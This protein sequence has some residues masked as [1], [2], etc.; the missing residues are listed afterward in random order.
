MLQTSNGCDSLV[1]L[2]LTVIPEA[3]SE[4]DFDICEGELFNGIPIENDTVFIQF[5]QN[6]FGCDSTVQ[7]NVN[8]LPQSH[9]E[10]EVSLCEGESYNGTVYTNDTIM[11]DLFTNF[12]GC[13][14]TVQTTVI[15]HPAPETN[16]TIIVDVTDENRIKGDDL[17][18]LDHARLSNDT[19]IISDTL[20]TIE[21][22]DSILNYIYI[23]L[24]PVET[25]LNVSLCEGDAYEGEVYTQSTILTEVYEAA[26]GLDSTVYTTIKVL[27]T[28]V[29]NNYVEICAGSSYE[30]AGEL[31]TTSGLY[32]DSLFTSNGCDSIIITQLEVLPVENTASIIEVCEGESADIHGSKETQ[33][34][35]Y[36]NTFT[37]ANGCD[38]MSTIELIVHPHFEQVLENQICIGETF[39]GI[40]IQNDTTFVENYNTIFGCDSTIITHISVL[41]H[42][43]TTIYVTLPVG[44]IYNEVTYHENSTLNDVIAASNGCDST[45]ITIITV[46][47]AVETF[48]NYEICE[49]ESVDGVSYFQ[50]TIFTQN[51]LTTQGFDSLVT[52]EITVNF[53]QY[54]YLQANSCEYPEGTEQEITYTDQN[55]CDSI[56][57]TTYTHIESDAV[58]LEITLCE[59]EE[60]EGFAYAESTT[61]VQESQ[62]QFGCDSTTTLMITVLPTPQINLE[63]IE[64]FCATESITIDLG[65]LETVIWTEQS[66]TLINNTISAGGYYYVQATNAFGCSTIDTIWVPAPTEIQAEVSYNP[67]PCYEPTSASITIDTVYGGTAPYT[68]SLNGEIQNN[69]HFGNLTNGIFEINIQDANGCEF[70]DVIVIEEEYTPLEVDLGEDLLIEW[71]ESVQLNPV[72]N[73]PS[74]VDQVFWTPSET[75]DCDDCLTP[76]ATPNET[77]VY[78][79][80]VVTHDGCETSDEVL[81]RVEKERNIYIPNAF[82][83]NDDGTNDFF[84]VYPG[85]GV[86]EVQLMRIYDRW[87]NNVFERHNFDPT[88]EQLGWDGNFRGKHMNP[89]VFVY[90]VEVL[91]ED[92]VVKLYKGDVTLL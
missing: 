38:S 71:G 22:C 4:L 66:D 36:E 58:E 34:G 46:I 82:T 16:D 13:D 76:T 55:G 91:F 75:L 62:N 44:G 85:Q 39:E 88:D 57:M 17:P 64:Q 83:P 77:T 68:Y 40:N 86:E 28:F 14:S 84:T 8:L 31:Q 15:V 92:G 65:D 37:T 54:T 23:Y 61:V 47:D 19:L 48:L 63:G 41:P 79:V 11:V 33:A 60:Y 49:G 42:S 2:A 6:Q 69:P 43:D 25:Y 50:D 29:E 78:E 20:T 56:V 12:W 80:T 7:T 21:G 5:L 59:G 52:T 9:S 24:F 30:A 67:P 3:G 51:L 81:L 74:Q 26:N 72:V 10:L 32:T 53:P 45:I 90:Y 1:T 18:N 27:P 73:N 87:G 70:N 89:G 35:I